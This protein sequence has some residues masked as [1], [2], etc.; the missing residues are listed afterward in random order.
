MQDDGH[1]GRVEELDR[2]GV[3]D[4]RPLA[5][6]DEGDRDLP[7]LEVDDQQEDDDGGED[8][9]D[10]G[11]ALAVEGVLEA[12]DLVGPGGGE[13]EGKERRGGTSRGGVQ[14]GSDRVRLHEFS[15]M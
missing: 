7:S 8:V 1:V 9:G 12:A 2:V 11:E 3:L 14:C 13:G 5:G 10:V 6:V 4:R 15:V